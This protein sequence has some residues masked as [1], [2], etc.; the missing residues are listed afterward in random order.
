MF[1]RSTA[2]E[3]PYVFVE[4]PEFFLRD[5]KPFGVCDGCFDL[6]TVTYDAGIAKQTLDVSIVVTG[7]SRRVKTMECFR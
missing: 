4:G 1:D 7:N 5:Q 3:L 2:N 6:E